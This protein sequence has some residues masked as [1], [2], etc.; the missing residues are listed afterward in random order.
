MGE[1]NRRIVAMGGGG[2]S[3]EPDNPL[4]DDHVLGLARAQR[5]RERPRV[6]FLA[7]ASGDSEGYVANFY[8]AFA[9]RSE[10]THL[11][12]FDR[13]VDDI[14]AFLLDQDAVYVGGG[15]TANMLAIWRVHGLDRA[16]TLAWEAGVVLAGLSVGSNCWFQASTT[17]SFGV[18]AALKDGLGL[19]P[20]S[21]SPHYDG[22]PGRRPLFQSLIA[23]GQLPDGL[24][25]DDGA[26]LVFDGTELAEV[27]ASRPSARAYRVVRGP[28]GEA[29]E[30]ELVTRYLG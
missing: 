12:L 14:E 22:E 1:P 18:L 6:C 17:D 26:A 11:A 4:L 9:R 24:A 10:A 19:V 7:T 2:F 15:N 28:G 16:L 27:V 23:S 30:T 5:G 25:A 3:M 13:K 29:I 21:H 8:A 20:G